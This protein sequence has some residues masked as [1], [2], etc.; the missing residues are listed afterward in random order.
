M[1]ENMGFN[2]RTDY[3]EGDIYCKDCKYYKSFIL[4]KSAIYDECICPQIKNKV[5]VVTGKEQVNFC[6]NE[7]LE[8]GRC[9]PN[10]KYFEEYKFP[11]TNSPW[12]IQNLEK[13]KKLLG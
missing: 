10:A 13:L 6:F 11:E 9:G 5:S 1:T 7:R 12:W 4:Y 8:S 3:A 2:S